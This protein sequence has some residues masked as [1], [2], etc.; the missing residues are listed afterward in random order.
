MRTSVKIII[1]ESMGIVILSM[2]S[3][4]YA[5]TKVSSIIHSRHTGAPGELQESTIRL[6]TVQNWHKAQLPLTASFTP[7]A[8]WSIDISAS[9]PYVRYL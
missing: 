7:G 8:T 6:G 3:H 4:K 9:I 1:S 5:Y 2:G